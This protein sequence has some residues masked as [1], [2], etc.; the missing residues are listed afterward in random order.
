[1][2]PVSLTE[3]RRKIDRVDSRIINLIEKRMILA[4]A[5]GQL[6]KSNGQPVEIKQREKKVLANWERQATGPGL[7]KKTII[8][9]ARLLIRVTKLK[10]RLI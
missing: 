10:E 2:K 5:I 8:E 4:M 9:I 1:M 6:K 3:L 7:D